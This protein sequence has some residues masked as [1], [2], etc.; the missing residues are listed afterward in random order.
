MVGR[1]FTSDSIDL[2]RGLSPENKSFRF[3]AESSKVN[4]KLFIEAIPEIDG[5]GVYAGNDI[6][7]LEFLGLYTGHVGYMRNGI[8]PIYTH[9]INSK[10]M[11]GSFQ[12]S[13]DDF[14]NFSKE[15]PELFYVDIDAK[16]RYLSKLLPSGHLNLPPDTTRGISIN[17]EKMGNEMRFVNHCHRTEDCNATSVL[18]WVSYHD[19]L[20]AYPREDIVA[21][22]PQEKKLFELIIHQPNWFEHLGV[23]KHALIPLSVFLATRD[24]SKGEQLLVDYGSQYWKVLNQVP[25][26]LP[27]KSRWIQ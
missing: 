27:L 9:S 21:S 25:I 15:H 23:K 8:G 5:F 12:I 2:I 1:H 10:I 3:T 11:I 13:P 20:S 22:S 26:P 7:K 18:W 6:K 14:F 24:I 4:P 17:A 16:G 19:F